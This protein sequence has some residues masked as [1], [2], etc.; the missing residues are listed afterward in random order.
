MG[1]DWNP[2][3][4][5]Q[6][7]FEQEFRELWRKLQAKSCFFRSRKVKRFH[8]ITV[9]A[10]DT[11]RTPRVGFDDAANEWV[12]LKAFPNRTD[13]SLTEEVFVQ[14]MKGFCVLELVPKCDGIP[15]YSNGQ[16]GGYVEGYAFRG[17]FLKD[18]LDVIGDELLKSG[19]VSK[20]PDETVA[21][22]AVLHKKAEDYAASRSI[23]LS[24]VH[25]IDDEDS[26]IYKLDI[27]LSAARWCRIWGERGHWLE[28][29]W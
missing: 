9:T 10:F 16:S 11:L 20:L 13:K 24:E 27:A 5:A 17:Q 2:G 1:L 29:Y 8:E 6:P 18:C 15:T 22:G 28:A 19:Y 12:R 25:S 26:P 14:R 21:Y 7:G 23:K 4:K 3:N